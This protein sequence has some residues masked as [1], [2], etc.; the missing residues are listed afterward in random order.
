MKINDVKVAVVGGGMACGPV[1]GNVT[2]EAKVTD[3]DRVFYAGLIEVDGAFISYYESETSLHDM[4]VEDEYEDTDFVSWGGEYRDYFEE[5]FEDPDKDALMRFLIYVV[6]A[7]WDDCNAFIAATKGHE[8]SE[9]D[10]PEYVDDEDDEWD[11][12][13]E[14]DEE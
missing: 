3:G 10:I 2:A 1:F 14:D 6:R 5:P 11:E 7:G 12:E 8:L 4:I 9:I 13:E